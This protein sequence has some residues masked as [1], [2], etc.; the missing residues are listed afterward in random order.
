MLVAIVLA[1]DL[2]HWKLDFSVLATC[3]IC[4]VG[5]PICIHNIMMKYGSTHRVQTNEC[6]T[7]IVK[8]TAYVVEPEGSIV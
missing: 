6:L 1:T 5:A 7:S 2:N 4:L 3:R 8:H